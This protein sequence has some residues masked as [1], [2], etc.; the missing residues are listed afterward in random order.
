MKLRIQ[1]KNYFNWSSTESPRMDDGSLTSKIRVSV[2]S[3]VVRWYF[4]G[5]ELHTWV[6]CVNA[7]CWVL[8]STWHVYWSRPQSHHDDDD[9]E[10]S[11]RALFFPR[12]FEWNSF[13]F[14]E[15]SPSFTHKKINFLLSLF[16]P[17]RSTHK[18][19]WSVFLRLSSIKT[20]AMKKRERR[21]R[22]TSWNLFWRPEELWLGLG[23]C[24]AP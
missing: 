22:G 6:V 14:I 9:R 4:F 11:T 18:T 7:V 15:S 8:R 10:P 1:I 23:C 3:F 12:L 19:R 21:R 5:Y 13:P 2:E 16:H 20:C 17:K 24:D